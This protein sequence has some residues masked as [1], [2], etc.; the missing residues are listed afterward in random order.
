MLGSLGE[1]EPREGEPTIKD[2]SALVGLFRVPRLF[3]LGSLDKLDWK[4]MRLGTNRW[5]WNPS[6]YNLGVTSIG[7]KA[8]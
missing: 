6:Y 1:L 7:S 4:L 3:W 8:T 5:A 2:Y